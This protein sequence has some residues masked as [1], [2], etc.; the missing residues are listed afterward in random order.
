MK[1]IHIQ[2]IFME[3]YNLI[4]IKATEEN[5]AI[6][7]IDSFVYICENFHKMTLEGFILKQ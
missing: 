3:K 1:A 7:K 6:N 2:N 5:S 4:K